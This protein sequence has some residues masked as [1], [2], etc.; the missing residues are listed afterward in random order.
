M[1]G[2]SGSGY[3]REEFEMFVRTIS[4]LTVLASMPIMGS[5]SLAGAADRDICFKDQKVLLRESCAS[6]PNRP[7]SL[8]TGLQ[9]SR[10]PG[11]DGF[12]LPGD[13]PDPKEP[14]HPG[15]LDGGKSNP[16]PG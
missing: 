6:V 8:G 12:D 1:L 5:I 10:R 16:A 7:A 9:H 2:Y 11:D 15:N 4:V 3:L 13:G 14:D